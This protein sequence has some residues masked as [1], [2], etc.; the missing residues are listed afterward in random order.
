MQN[1]RAWNK[2]LAEAVRTWK[3]PNGEYAEDAPRKR[4]PDFSNLQAYRYINRIKQGARL[5]GLESP[6]FHSQEGR[7][8]SRA[9][10]D[11]QSR[12]NFAW[13]NYLC[14]SASA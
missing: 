7:T 13:C 3:S 10:V 2:R 8:G 12:L 5:I 6:F 4:P 1:A 14:E 11:G 9:V